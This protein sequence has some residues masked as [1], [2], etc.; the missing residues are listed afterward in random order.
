[1]LLARR[2]KGT[3]TLEYNGSEAW[4][5]R[6]WGKGGAFLA[7]LAYFE[8]AALLAA[9]R[10]AVVSTVLADELRGLGVAG[11]RIRVHPNGVDPGVCDSS[12][13]TAE[14]I[15]DVRAS[16]GIAPDALVVT[17]VG[18]FGKWHGAE[19]LADAVESWARE[20][21]GRRPAARGVRPRVT[22]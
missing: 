11:H 12:R 5:A 1:L 2:Y 21:P 6:K 20:D 3:C 22:A 19:I 18:T 13:V 10:V 16:L 17:F 14:E 15:S 8:R 9:D 7:V 4:V